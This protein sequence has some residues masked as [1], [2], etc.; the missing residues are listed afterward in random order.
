LGEKRK[1]YIVLERTL[2]KSFCNMA[3][4]FRNRSNKVL[5]CSD[6]QEVVLGKGIYCA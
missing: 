2:L 1:K 5:A 3:L 6:K 4:S